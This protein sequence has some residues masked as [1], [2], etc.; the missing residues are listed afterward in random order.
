MTTTGSGAAEILLGGLGDDTL[1]GGGGSDSIRG[2]AGDDTLSV[3]DLA[4][5]SIDGGGGSD[6]LVLTGSGQNFDFTALA[7][8]TVANIETLDISGSGNN[9]LTLGFADIA[10]MNDGDPFAFTAASSHHALV[11]E[12]DAGDTV[13]LQDY[14]P[15]GA[16][17]V[18]PAAWTL[19]HAGV[20]LDGSSGGAYDIYDLVRGSDVLASVA[21]DADITRI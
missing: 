21:M 16:G 14:D 12:G 1:T 2:G 17:G 13:T 3:P 5:R 10:A 19:A 18:D 4:F 15:D 9:D 7:N 20:N 6:T 8:T 11:I